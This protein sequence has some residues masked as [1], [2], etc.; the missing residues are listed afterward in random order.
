MG[1]DGYFGWPTALRLAS[2]IEDRVIL[3][4]NCFRRAWVKEVG[5]VIVVPV[6]SIQNRIST[7]AKNLGVANI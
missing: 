7:A 2:R 3:V 6:A 5:A 4:D 1:G